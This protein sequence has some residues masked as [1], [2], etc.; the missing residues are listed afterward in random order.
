M[1]AAERLLLEALLCL[2]A[3]VLLLLLIMVVLVLRAIRSGITVCSIRWG[4]IMHRTAKSQVSEDANSSN[5]DSLLLMT[6]IRLISAPSSSASMK[7]RP[8]LR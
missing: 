8:R 6:L 3:T 4:L 5:S 2:R 7:G 1:I